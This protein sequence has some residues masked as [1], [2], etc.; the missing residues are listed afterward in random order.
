MIAESNSASS[1]EEAL[2][3]PGMDGKLRR[4]KYVD[5]INGRLCI[6][7]EF[8]TKFKFVKFYSDVETSMCD[9]GYSKDFGCF[10]ENQF[11]KMSKSGSLV[12]KD[13]LVSTFYLKCPMSAKKEINKIIIKFGPKFFNGYLN[14]L[15][16]QERRVT[17]LWKLFKTLLLAHGWC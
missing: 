15:L 13:Y 16:H 12:T 2:F 8:D 1:S 10:E 14:D 3:I 17:K 11:D 6:P 7:K 9:L 5:E 4:K